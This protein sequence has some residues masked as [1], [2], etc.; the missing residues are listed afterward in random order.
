M[1]ISVLAHDVRQPFANIIMATDLL[2]QHPEMVSEADRNRIFSELR[3]N[4]EQSIFF[5]DGVLYW[6]KARRQGVELSSERLSVTELLREANLFLEPLQKQRN[7]AI[8][9]NLKGDEFVFGNQMVLTFAMRNILH[10]A[11]KFSPEGTSIRIDLEASEDA[12][13]IVI[14]D[15]GKGMDEKTRASLFQPKVDEM[16]SYGKGAGVAL[17]IAY[18]MLKLTG[19]TI[20]V[21]SEPGKGTVFSI[22]C[23]SPL[24]R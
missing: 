22:K 4:T 3:L 12:K 1:L 9:S 10:N 16:G 8:K 6:I 18:E 2:S 13:T 24:D 14:Q 19:A 21:E 15:E 20:S 7:I 5:M 23:P 17:A 11:T